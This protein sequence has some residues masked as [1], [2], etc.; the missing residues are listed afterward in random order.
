MYSE[1]L[2]KFWNDASDWVNREQLTELYNVQDNTLNQLNKPYMYV[3]G[4]RL[5]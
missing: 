4:S 3:Y 2:K 1:F 5:E